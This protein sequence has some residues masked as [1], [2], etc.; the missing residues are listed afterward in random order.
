MPRTRRAGRSDAFG[1]NQTNTVSGCCNAIIAPWRLQAWDRRGSLRWLEISSCAA[2]LDRR[3]ADDALQR[4]R[5]L[6]K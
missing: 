1:P 4:A 3:Y 5:V 6:A 2:P